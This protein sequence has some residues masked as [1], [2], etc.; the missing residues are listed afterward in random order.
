MGRR[1]FTLIELLVVIAIIGILA[2]ILLPALARAREAARRSS[3]QNNLKQ[4]G[5]VFKMYANEAPAQ[6]FPHIK[7][8][9]CQPKLQPWNAIFEGE[10]LIPEYLNDLDLLICPS[11]SH[12]TNALECFDQGKTSSPLW[13]SV[14]GYTGNGVVELCELNAEPYLYYGFALHSG[15]FVTPQDFENFNPAL[16]VWDIGL[17]AAYAAKGKAGAAHFADQDWKLGHGYTLQGGA[18]DT[19]Y[20]LREGIER[21]MVTDINNPG[22]S[23]RAQSEIV[24][25]HDALFMDATH[26]NHVPGGVNVLY[27]DG[28]VEYLTWQPQALLNAPFPLNKA[29]LLLHEA[30]ETETN[31]GT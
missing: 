6:R 14:D 30:G 10:G 29:G 17:E 21:F 8:V 5:L 31:D 15:H 20:R 1:G 24:V 27:L 18:V 26:F 3:C 2:A 19:V 16:E 11:N 25:M 13:K 9:D 28:H 12:S 22:A 23:S 7:V 4:L